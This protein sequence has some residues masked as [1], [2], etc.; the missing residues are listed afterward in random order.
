MTKHM[1]STTK[2]VQVLMAFM[3]SFVL[4]GTDTVFSQTIED[5]MECHMD[6]NLSRTDAAGKV[7]SQY[8]DKKKFLASVHGELDY[9]CVDCH[10][11]AKAEN[12]PKEGLID[13]KCGE[14]HEEVLKAYEES[15]HGQLLKSGNSDA[16]QCYDCHSIHEVLSSDHL[17]STTNPENLSITCGKCHADEAASPLPSLVKA[18]VQGRDDVI[19][20]GVKTSLLSII[21]TRIKGHGKVNMA[22]DF[23][24]RR[25]N[26]CH[27]EVIRHADDDMK[28]RICVNCHA[29]GKSIVLFGTIHTSGISK[30]PLLIISMIILYIVGIVGIV[31]YFK[32]STAKKKPEEKEEQAI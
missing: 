7:H 13:V 26:D 5:C 23:S 1:F 18:S 19:T 20:P 24:T 16:P 9:N 12:H 10:E 28:P 3:I 17:L 21:P 29:M 14:C 2:T 27:F 31:F 15:Q 4:L 30:S 11:G 8:V 32:S 22:W 6:R 25:C